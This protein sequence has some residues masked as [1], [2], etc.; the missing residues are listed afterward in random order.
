M[1]MRGLHSISPARLKI[2]IW[3][4]HIAVSLISTPLLRILEVPGSYLGPEA[5]YLD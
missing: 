4:L 1:F 3:I 2:Y 5:G